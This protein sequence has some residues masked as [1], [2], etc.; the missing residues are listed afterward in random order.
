MK[1]KIKTA[2]FA[3]AVLGCLLL[4][5]WG[6]ATMS[7]SSGEEQKDVETLIAE[8]TDKKPMV[9]RNAVEALGKLGDERAV[10]PLIAKLKK[11]KDKGVRAAAAKALG[12]IGDKRALEP[13]IAKLKKDKDWGVRTAAAEA[14]GVLGDTKAV[15]PL[16]AK[17][18]KDKTHSVQRASAEALGEIGDNRAVEP[19]IATLKDKVNIV[20]EAAAEALGKIGD[21]RAVEPLIVEFK[22]SRRSSIRKAAATALSKIG[23]PAVKPL[24]VALNDKDR[25]VR[26]EAAKV[27]GEIGD[28]RAVEPL[29]TAMKDPDRYV[30]EQA[31]N[32]ISRMGQKAVEPLIV[33]LKDN[34]SKVREVAVKSLGEIGDETAVEPLIVALKDESSSVRQKAAEALGKIKDERAV[35]PLI[36]LLK[37]TDWQL[38][39]IVTEALTRIGAPAVEPLIVAFNDKNGQIREEA[40]KI[41]SQIGDER[42]VVPLIA[43]LNDKNRSVQKKVKEALVKI[44]QPAVKPLVGALKDGGNTRKEAISI[45]NKLSW[46]PAN[47]AD[48]AIWFVA[49]KKWD[50]C[51]EL[52]EPAVD[53]LIGALQDNDVRVRESAAKTLVQLGWEPVNN[54]DKAAYYIAGKEWDKCVE[55]GVTAVSPLIAASKYNYNDA[56]K[57]LVK[58]GKP[59]VEL[60]L[61]TATGN[62]K[63]AKSFSMS[64][65]LEIKDPRAIDIYIELLTCKNPDMRLKAARILLGLKD[66]KAVKLRAQAKKTIAAETHIVAKTTCNVY[67]LPTSTTLKNIN[68]K[69]VAIRVSK[70]NGSFIVSETLKV[71]GKVVHTTNYDKYSKPINR[72]WLCLDKNGNVIRGKSGKPLL[73]IFKSARQKSVTTI[74]YGGFN[75]TIP[76]GKTTKIYPC[77]NCAKAT[78]LKNCVYVW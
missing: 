62:D 4:L 64:V 53:P 37:S 49:T 42:A 61:S 52:G 18:R 27:L 40:A 43:A 9:R 32:A 67:G 14:L 13:L 51:V 5:G 26:A 7:L 68:N 47:D 78:G 29:F 28:S 72:K 58:I 54:S 60:L 31:S 19:L 38:K 20:R 3:V 8:L 74:L 30:K 39:K 45:L 50:M 10:E 15:E 69:V 24:I 70:F 75:P 16:I 36:V 23:Q 2:R 25:I 22:D 77:E 6:A 59:A 41:L 17:L 35:D 55:L 76:S 11:D 44:G 12:K 56:H 66:P 34:D 46:K 71:D 1:I 65:L 63:R 33:A 21:E 57:T 73:K 48:K